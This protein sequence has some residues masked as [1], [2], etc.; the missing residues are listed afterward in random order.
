MGLAGH[1]GASNVAGR[2]A[3]SATARPVVFAL[4]SIPAPAG[5]VQV[6]HREAARSDDTAS[7]GAEEDERIPLVRS[8]DRGDLAH[9]GLASYRQLGSTRRAAR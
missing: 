6:A 2:E 4:A 5:A 3:R 1:R 7:D 9:K 8:Q